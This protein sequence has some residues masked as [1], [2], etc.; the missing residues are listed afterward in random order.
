MTTDEIKTMLCVR[1]ERNPDHARVFADGKKP[2]V[3]GEE[4][5]CWNCWAG[6]SL[7]AAD[8]LRNIEVLEQFNESIRYGTM[9]NPQA[10][11]G[12]GQ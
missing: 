9:A 7:Y 3:P 12:G 6:R 8:A 10:K 2:G 5:G 1:D 4:C 11:E